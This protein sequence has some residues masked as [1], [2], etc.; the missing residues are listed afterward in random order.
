MRRML[1]P[2]ALPLWAALFWLLASPLVW[3]EDGSENP[4]P[5]SFG[6]TGTLGTET[7]SD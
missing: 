1:I 3:A 4:M 7:S 6:L 2:R 5:F